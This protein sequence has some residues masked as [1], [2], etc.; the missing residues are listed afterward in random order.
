MVNAKIQL[1]S[2]CQVGMASVVTK[3]LSDGS[4]VFGN[5]ARALPTMGRF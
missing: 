5:P 2:D 4:S 3:S 1:G